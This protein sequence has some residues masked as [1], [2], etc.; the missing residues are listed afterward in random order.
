MNQILTIEEIISK[1]ESLKFDNESNPLTY[2]CDQME[3][4]GILLVTNLRMSFYYKDS[5]DQLIFVHYLFKMINKIKFYPNTSTNIV[6][7]N[8]DYQWTTFIFRSKMNTREFKEFIN[9]NFND[10]LDVSENIKESPMKN[11]VFYKNEKDIE[12]TEFTEKRKFIQFDNKDTVKK[13]LAGLILFSVNIAGII[14]VLYFTS[15]F[16][17]KFNYEVSKVINYPSY[18]L[19]VQRCDKD[20]FIISS[21]MNLNNEYPSDLTTFI[22]NNFK[23]KGSANP[24]KDPWGSLYDINYNNQNTFRLISYGPDKKENTEDDVIREFAKIN[25]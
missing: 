13:L 9:K 15:L 21:K 1:H 5:L 24:A 14:A 19:N 20:M 3:L 25:K 22:L 7:V 12:Q 11:K 4:N 18:W 6:E 17:P 2:R 23:I 10:K 8:Y 16:F